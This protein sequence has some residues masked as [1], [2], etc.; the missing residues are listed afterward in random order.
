MRGETGTRGQGDMGRL[1]LRVRVESVGADGSYTCAM[2]I[3]FEQAQRDLGKVLERVAAGEEMVITRDGFPVARV[4]GMQDSVSHQNGDS[5]SGAKP[6]RQL[7][8]AKNMIF[9][10]SP[11]FDEPLEDFREYMERGF[12]WTHTP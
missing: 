4:V 10:I 8:W 7:G 12:W 2:T 3:P 11:D 9:S 1:R 5:D 6:E